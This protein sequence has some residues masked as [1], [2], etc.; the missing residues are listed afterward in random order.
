MKGIIIKKTPLDLILGGNKTW[1][2][3]GS[4]ATHRGFVGLVV[5]FAKLVD[6]IKLD[7]EVFAS[8]SDRHGSQA[9]HSGY[10][11]PYAWVLESPVRL[12]RA[13]PYQHKQGCV[14]WVNIDDSVV[15]ESMVQA[16]IDSKAGPRPPEEVAVVARVPEPRPLPPQPRPGRSGGDH[17]T[18]LEHLEKHGYAVVPTDL[19]VAQA[20]AYF[21]A[22]I[23]NFPEFNADASKYVLG[24]FG[25]LGNPAS[26]HNP[27]VRLLRVWAHAI[28]RPLLAPLA[29]TQ[30]G[31]M[32]FE[33]VVDRMMV[34]QKGESAS[35]EAWHRDEAKLAGAD[36]LVFGGWWNLDSTAQYFSCIAGSHKVVSG[37]KG[38]ATVKLSAELKA[39]MRR[40]RTK[41][42]FV[43]GTSTHDSVQVV[44]QHRFFKKFG[45]KSFVRGTSVH[46][47]V[48][49]ASPLLY[50]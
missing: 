15:A 34:R 29:G 5:G 35:A 3:R 12:Q 17:L 46:D 20:R 14:I 2:I 4:P 22:E 11:T 50:A 8:H 26:F 13:L 7:N 28:I 27:T 47:S 9:L 23:A 40:D 16:Y 21:D 33:Q 42:S 19:D 6:C 38:F 1:G 37:N 48:Q 41:V 49:V 32:Y 10:K 18:V 39:Q 45:K 31:P 44:S 43:R 25:A 36:D 24:G 30:G